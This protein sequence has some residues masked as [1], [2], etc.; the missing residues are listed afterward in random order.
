MADGSNPEVKTPDSGTLENSGSQTVSRRWTLKAGLAATAAAVLGIRPK[1]ADAQLFPTGFE[2][3]KPPEA[4][5]AVKP[6][7]K[8]N[9]PESQIPQDLRAAVDKKTQIAKKLLY[10][11]PGQEPPDIILE[12]PDVPETRATVVYG[13]KN[14][15]N[16]GETTIQDARLQLSYSPQEPR[17]VAAVSLESS[18]K[19]GILVRE[20]NQNKDLERIFSNAFEKYLG[21]SFDQITMGRATANQMAKLEEIGH[22]F[23]FANY[24]N[25]SQSKNI[26]VHR[27]R[28]QLPD[29]LFA[30][31][32]AIWTSEPE[33]LAQK[34]EQANASS[35]KAMSDVFLA[36]LILILDCAPKEASFKSV[37][38]EKSHVLR[39]L[40]I[41]DHRQEYEEQINQRAA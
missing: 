21:I 16:P 33:Q 4:P 34:L 8:A 20:S 41:S 39:V 11:I 32:F 37:G 19:L 10:N 26:F 5:L 18:E 23:D 25:D 2:P 1:Q 36:A 14:L 15:E 13:F 28:S 3:H 24:T 27:Q 29:N 38:I 6:E 12:Y 9:S 7:V 17:S 22:L 31:A 35:K 40:A 30:K